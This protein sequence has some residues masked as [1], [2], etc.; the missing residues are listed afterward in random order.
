LV[1]DWASRRPLY[2]QVRDALL[3]RIT[4]GTWKPQMAIPNEQELAREMG[5]SAG[6]MRKALELLEAE[7]LVTRRQGRGT[8]VNDQASEQL[9][10]R[11]S[12]LRSL[13]GERVLGHRGEG[14]VVADKASIEERQRLLLNEGALVYRIHR[15]RSHLG[16]TCIVEDVSLP[17]ERFSGLVEAPDPA[18]ELTS[19]ARD[20]GVLLG[21]AE[22]RVAAVVPPEAVALMLGTAANQPVL[23][24]D[25]IVRALDSGIPVEWRTAHCRWDDGCYVADI[26]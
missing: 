21:E 3:E 19:L 8:F 14:K 9:A 24:L 11:F 16:R 5:V 12:N 23:L 22:E 18:T 6:T 7:H 20:H 26:R 25:R 15:T 10:A 13:D 2:L 4:S 17:A 1:S